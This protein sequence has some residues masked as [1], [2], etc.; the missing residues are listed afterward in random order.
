MSL[1]RRT[2]SARI[3]IYLSSPP[4]LYTGVSYLLVQMMPGSAEVLH[5]YQQ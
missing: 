4:L 5:L 3:I 1:A 2:L